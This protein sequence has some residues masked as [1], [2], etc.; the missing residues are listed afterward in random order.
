MNMLIKNIKRIPPQESNC[1]SVDSPDK[2][3]VIGEGNLLTH[4]SVSQQN[5]II[6][7]LLRPKHWVILGIDLKRVELTRFKKFGV[8]VATD[9]DTAVEF[10]RFAQAVMMKRYERMEELGV[11]DFEDLPEQ[12]QALMVM[13]DEA[14]ELLS[15]S[16]AKALAASTII[17]KAD[18]TFTTMKELKVGEEILDNYSKPTKVTQKYTPSEQKKY[19]LEISSDNTG[20][21]EKFVAGEE[22]LW[23]VYIANPDRTVDGPFLMETS[24]LKEE[25]DLERNKKPSEKRKFKFKRNL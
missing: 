6:S 7:C 3:F 16:G 14:G 1:I 21:K 17:P 24:Q 15:P 23:V 18:G 8:K 5:I 4:N 9:L 11:N 19:K 10:L 12:L 25:M 2:L 22:H 20:Q 13:I